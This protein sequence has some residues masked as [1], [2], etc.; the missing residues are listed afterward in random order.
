M[1]GEVS[2][3][4]FVELVLKSRL[5]D[6]GHI[7]RAMASRTKPGSA[8]APPPLPPT[9]REFADILVRAGDLTHFQAAKLLHGRWAGLA[10]GPYRILAP[11]GRGGMGTVYL[12]RD[13]RLSE[14]QGD[15]VLMALK[16]LPP[17][18]AREQER[19]LM[20]FQ[21]EIDMGKRT[22]HP[23][24][25]RTLAGG[26]LDGV[27]Y[28]AMEYVPG[29]SLQRLVGQGGRI[30]V[31]EAA[32]VF[33]D[34]AAG[35]QHLHDRNI[36]HRDLKPANVMVTPSGEAKILDLGLA[37]AL[38]EPLPDDPRIVGGKGYILGTMDYIAPEQARNATDV[39][40]HTDLYS[41]GCA[42]YFTLSGTP[43]FPGGTSKDKIRR[44][45]TLEPAPLS[46][47]NPAVP[48]RLAR[49]VAKLMAK[50]P[51]DRPASA[52]AARELLLPF[53]TPSITTPRPTI[54]DA[55]VAVDTPETFPELWTDDSD[56]EGRATHEPSSAGSLP[57]LYMPPDAPPEPPTGLSRKAWL[58]IV[59]GVLWMILLLLLIV[60]LLR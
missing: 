35:L 53:A 21:R 55:V 22:G 39:G 12:A 31:G 32:R 18:I 41:L 43:P 3:E 2:L 59:G 9:A 13:A 36:I 37:L 50:T 17:R 58:L 46:D 38:G 8:K 26:E 60:V 25:T 4:A 19:M 5:L 44:Q 51:T 27:N 14:E 6:Q 49:V 20:R 29:R 57:L 24:V 47:M 40:P 42:L 30:P 7:D 15:E 52:S 16:I 23:N 56:G 48:G 34:V 11:L 33:A 1:P 54:R 45:R 10:L 28:I